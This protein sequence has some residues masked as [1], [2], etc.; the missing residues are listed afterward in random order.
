MT[1]P[2]LNIQ[3]ERPNGLYLSGEILR[4]NVR[5]HN[6]DA[7][8]IR[9]LECSVL[10]YT[11]GQGEEDMAVHFFHREKPIRT[12]SVPWD[13]PF[14]MECVLPA[15]PLTYDGILVKLSWCVRARL[16]L[17]QGREVVDEVAFRLGQVPAATMVREI[18]PSETAIQENG[19]FF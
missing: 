15:S 16:F 9:A 7:I 11:V 2:Q 10:W 12:G 13:Q 8:V 14:S 18:P 17:E 6:P 3:L 4:T 19:H 5:I 1:R